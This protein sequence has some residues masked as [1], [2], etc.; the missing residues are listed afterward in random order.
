[1]RM[2]IRNILKITALV[3]IFVMISM[4][5][6]SLTVGN[7]VTGDFSKPG[8]KPVPDTCPYVG[9]GSKLN[10]NF[11]YKKWCE[12]TF[13]NGDYVY[14]AYKN[15]AFNIEYTPE[16]PETD[17]WQT[18]LETARLKKGDCEDAVFHFF[19][20]LLPKQT[21][22]EIVWGCVIDKRNGVGWAHV[23][24]QLTDK[25]GQKYVV[26][27]FSNDWN[28]IIPMIIIEDT[29]SR[30]PILTITHSAV[31]KFTSSLPKAD[32]SQ[33]PQ[34]LVDLFAATNF[35]N[36]DSGNIPFSQ[37]K[38]TLLLAKKSKEISNILNKL[39]EVFSRYER[40]KENANMQA[41]YKG[42]MKKFYPER[43][44]I[45]KR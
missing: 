45:C 10:D 37:G 13:Y 35:F 18:P 17:F 24:Y 4:A 7:E 38:Y 21:N 20:Q 40:Q 16:P 11:L 39:H 8:Y 32:N 25:K 42:N 2:K 26:E 41:V 34:S 43:N 14:E 1:M 29:E 44:L 28:G 31:G 12:E 3:C 30:R 23:W 5:N 36:C 27:G 15:I 33:N 9:D 22:A 19:S 6:I